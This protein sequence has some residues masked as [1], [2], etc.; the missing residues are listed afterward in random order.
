MKNNPVLKFFVFTITVISFQI[1]LNNISFAQ[2]SK[3]SEK[4]IPQTVL[5]SFKKLYP[6]ATI[7]GYDKENHKE[8]VTYEIESKD[9]NVQRDVEFKADGSIVEIGESVDVSSLPKNITNTINAKFSNANILEAEKKTRGSE[10]IY[11][12]IIN[13]KNKKR[14]VLLNPKGSII[15][16]DEDDEGK[17]DDGD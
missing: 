8:N 7:T 3:Y 14:E 10:I 5:E 9:G 12:V 16:D 2:E 6:N 15:K 17:E 4:D 11:E 13:D 1:I